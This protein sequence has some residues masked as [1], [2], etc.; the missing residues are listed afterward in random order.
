MYKYVG[1]L[2][3]PGQG[4]KKGLFQDN[5]LMIVEYESSVTNQTNY[6]PT[7]IEQTPIK[8]ISLPKR[9]KTK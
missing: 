1:E 6:L 4:Y 2:Y 7:E 3:L 5:T 9:Q 8:A